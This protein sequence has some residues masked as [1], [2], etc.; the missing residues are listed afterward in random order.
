MNKWIITAESA[1]DLS[2]ELLKQYGIG[3]LPITVIVDGKEYK[4]GIDITADELFEYVKKCGQ[5]P[6]TAAVSLAVPS[7]VFWVIFRNTEEFKRLKECLKTV[8]GVR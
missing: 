7:A 1:C 5:L 4:D 8:R 3:I 6:K 2:P